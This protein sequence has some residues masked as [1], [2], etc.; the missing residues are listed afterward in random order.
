MNF[1][2]GNLVLFLIKQAFYDQ[3]IKYLY[4]FYTF[5]NN[6]LPKRCFKHL[7]VLCN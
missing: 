7:T 6:N 3:I 1:I 5:M 4:L 2:S